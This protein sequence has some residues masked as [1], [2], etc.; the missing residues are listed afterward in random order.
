MSF[1]SPVGVIMNNVRNYTCVTV[2]HLWFDPWQLMR[3]KRSRINVRTPIFF[4]RYKNDILFMGISSF[5]DYPL[6]SHN[7]FSPR[8]DEQYVMMSAPTA[9]LRSQSL[10]E[11][12]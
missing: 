12:F 10:I 2:F 3:P 9:C 4:I 1:C 6:D 8:L 5:E 7:P 11:Y